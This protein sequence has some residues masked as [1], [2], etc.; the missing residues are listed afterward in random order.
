MCGVKMTGLDFLVF[1]LCCF[2]HSQAT[3]NENKPIQAFVIPHSHMDVGWVYTI[4][5]T[6]LF[7]CLDVRG[8]FHDN[9]SDMILKVFNVINSHVEASYLHHLLVID[10]IHPLIF[11]I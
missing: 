2:G 3:T 11:T 5:V 7:N 6:S 8:S 4:Q 9:L 1:F 10:L